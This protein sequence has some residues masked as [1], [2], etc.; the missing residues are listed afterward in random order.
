MS[1]K[2]DS[3]VAG[4]K[5]AEAITDR[6]QREWALIQIRKQHQLTVKEFTQLRGLIQNQEVG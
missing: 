4:L 2:L 1:K 5:E 3:L 6:L